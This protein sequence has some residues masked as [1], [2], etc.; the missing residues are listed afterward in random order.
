M[1]SMAGFFW[2]MVFLAGIIGALRGWAREWL[3]TSSVVLAFLIIWVVESYWPSVIVGANAQPGE[4][5]VTP[6]PSGAGPAPE[7]TP[8]PKPTLAPGVGPMATS[9]LEPLI[10]DEEE[11]N[12]WPS[13]EARNTFWFRTLTLLILAFFGYQTPRIPAV[14]SRTAKGKGVVADF[15]LGF[16][17]G[18]FNGYLI[19]GSLWYFLDQVNYPF[20]AIMA[21]PDKVQPLAAM[22]ENYLRYMP[23]NFLLSTPGIFI[24]V[25][26]AFVFVITVLV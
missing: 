8:A 26:V 6:T 1:L 5:V 9:P 3:V 17:F 18:M 7:L 12:P 4:A 15:L 11:G 2:I 23:P 21:P 10:P 25:I 24:A 22:V 20:H 14:A 19:I 16:F 13:K